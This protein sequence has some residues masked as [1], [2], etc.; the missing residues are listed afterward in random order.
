MNIDFCKENDFIRFI[1]DIWEWIYTGLAERDFNIEMNN[2]KSKKVIFK[3]KGKSQSSILNDISNK[4]FDEAINK[5]SINYYELIH[6][7]EYSYMTSFNT[8]WDFSQFVRFSEKCLLYN[9]NQKKPLYIDSEL[10]SEKEHRMYIPT[11]EFEIYIKLNKIKDE[12]LDRE[13]HNVYIKVIHK[14]GKKMVNEFV[15]VNDQPKYNDIS[16][17]ILL[18]NIR[19]ILKDIFISTLGEILI[20]NLKGKYNEVIR[21]NIK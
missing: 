21:R 10:Y 19:V 7:K 16:D 15:I 2:Y 13:F 8:L 1:S 18:G 14:E 5:I 11:D 17:D 6:N 20:K 3:N 9:N 4:L 12:I